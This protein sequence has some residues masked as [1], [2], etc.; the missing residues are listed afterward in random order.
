M[1]HYHGS[2]ITPCYVA[3]QVFRARHA[4]ISFADTRDIKLAS[5]VCQSFALDNGAFPAWKKGNTVDWDK[6]SNWVSDW[7]DH[8]NF[9]FCVIPDVIDGTEEDNDKLIESWHF[10]KSI[11]APVWHLHESV[12]KLVRLAKNYY[13]ICLG[14]SGQYSTVGTKDWW[15]RI[16][17]ALEAITVKGRPICKL[18]GLRMLNPAIFSKLPLSS[19]DSTNVARNHK[20]LKRA[21]HYIILDRVESVN[22]ASSWVRHDHIEGG[23]F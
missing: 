6:Y 2:P 12:E 5:E 8:P 4:F 23:L 21:G 9:D 19:A 7:C 20:D 10:P 17:E 13:R 22:S 18:H 16:D 14:S 1:I 15:L 3:L 11:S